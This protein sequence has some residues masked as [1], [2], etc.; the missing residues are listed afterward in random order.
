M[1][2][3]QRMTLIVENVIQEKMAQLEQRIVAQFIDDGSDSGDSSAEQRRAFLTP[4]T[5]GDLANIAPEELDAIQRD[6]D[7]LEEE[8]GMV[9]GQIKANNSK[10]DAI[11]PEDSVAPVQ[12]YINPTP[13]PETN[14]EDITNIS[15]RLSMVLAFINFLQDKNDG[16]QDEIDDLKDRLE[17]LEGSSGSD[18][19][20]DAR[21]E[22]VDGIDGL[23]GPSGD[24]G[25]PPNH[26]LD[27]DTHPNQ[28]YIRWEVTASYADENPSI[29]EGPDK[30]GRYWG[31]WIAL[32]RGRD[33]DDGA[34]GI[35]GTDGED[36]GTFYEELRVV[37]QNHHHYYCCS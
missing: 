22:G 16:L 15:V 30:H 4:E 27:L 10:V 33:G 3:V 37:H 12:E 32:P 17:N 14:E 28:P 19:A 5:L 36:G 26:E 8:L 24:V 20:A 34:D 25:P 7:A 31:E 13:L 1:N 29:T 18:A 23:Q 6:L 35:N 2:L 21:A 9:S 11:D